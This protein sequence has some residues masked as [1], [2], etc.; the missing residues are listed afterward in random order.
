MN[1]PTRCLFLAGLSL[2][3]GGA[4]A[5]VS[6][7]PLF[8]DHMVLQRDQPVPVWGTADPGESVTVEFNGQSSTTVAVADSTWRV[9]LHPLAASAEPASL[10]VHGKNHIE[11]Q[12]VLVGEV[13]LCS[14][15][16]NMEKPIGKQG[17]QQ[18]TENH[19]QVIAMANHPLIRLFQVPK[20]GEVTNSDWQMQWLPCSPDSLSGSRFSAVGYF[21]AKH[22]QERLKIPVGVINSSFGGT[23]IEAWTPGVAFGED[24][25]LAP[26]LYRRFFAWVEGVQATEL[27]TS[28]IAPLV[29]YGLRGFLWYQGEAN[30]MYAESAEYTRKMMALV[31]AWRNAFDRPDAP[32]LFVQLAPFNYSAWDKFPRQLTEQALPLFWEAQTKALAIPDTAMAVIT[33]LAGNARDI[34]P[35]RKRE[36]GERL[37]ALAE[38]ML[39]ET[40]STGGRHKSPLFEKAH[41]KGRHLVVEFR[42]AEG[43][44]KTRD[45]NTPTGFQIA[46][47]DQTFYPASAIIHQHKVQLSSPEVEHP[48]AVRFNWLETASTNLVS[49]SGLP[50]T[51][52]RT[53]NWP[54]INEKPHP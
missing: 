8:C 15:Q 4:S 34:H 32:F 24:P 44:L 9:M 52:F 50:A 16:S 36:V 6:L 53:D 2:A 1:C 47:P 49:Q 5:D 30:L 10:V 35:V 11:I 54:I 40:G 28:M 26:L 29:P 46:G 3:M 13:W 45:G 17:G 33:D 27:Y 39:Q 21:F 41:I 25:L 48:V 23:M 14:G 37:A 7:P 19:E 51:P 38:D 12:D 43:G 22:L 20:S 18:P 31:K 42:Y